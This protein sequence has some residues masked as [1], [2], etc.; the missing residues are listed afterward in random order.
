MVGD[1]G[2]W[3]RRE[4]KE[5][6]ENDTINFKITLHTYIPL[7]SEVSSGCDDVILPLHQDRYF[8]AARRLQDTGEQLHGLLQDIRRAH[9]DLCHHHKHGNTESQC[10][11]KVLWG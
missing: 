10:Q 3:R 6:I 8:P 9:V 4:E 11:A 7:R 1:R 2:K 5:S